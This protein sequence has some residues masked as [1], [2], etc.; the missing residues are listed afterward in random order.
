MDFSASCASTWTFAR[1]HVRDKISSGY[2]K[3]EVPAMRWNLAA[4]LPYLLQREVYPALYSRL[5]ISMTYKPR[6]PVDLLLLPP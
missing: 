5:S 4:A 3:I 1:H 2:L 6:S